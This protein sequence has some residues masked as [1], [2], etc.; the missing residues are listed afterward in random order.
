MMMMIKE[1]PFR[2][3][4]GEYSLRC[5]PL[6]STSAPTWHGIHLWIK[7]ENFLAIDLLDDGDDVERSSPE[8]VEEAPIGGGAFLGK[9][10]Q[11]EIYKRLSFFFLGRFQ[12]TGKSK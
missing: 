9:V 1:T 7:I 3:L 4:F 10:D 2:P 12:I 8:G 11:A 6:L 5:Q